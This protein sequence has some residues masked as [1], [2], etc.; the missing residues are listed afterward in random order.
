MRYLKKH[1]TRT[2]KD[3]SVNPG[4]GKYAG[5]NLSPASRL[6]LDLMSTYVNNARNH[7]KND[8]VARERIEKI[9]YLQRYYATVFGIP[10]WKM[11]EILQF[12][13]LSG[14]FEKNKEF[15]LACVERDQKQANMSRQIFDMEDAGSDEQDAEFARLAE[16]SIAEAKRNVMIERIKTAERAL[17]V[18]V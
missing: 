12:E 15:I 10:L 9:L 8:P 5:Q 7:Y 16:K 6:E 2:N 1:K 13:A 17:G 18:S 14:F 11:L 4:H 3:G